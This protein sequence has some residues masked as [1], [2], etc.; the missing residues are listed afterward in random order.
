MSMRVVN[1]FE[2]VEVEPQNRGFP[3][4]WLVSSKL[5]VEGWSIAEA[6]QG[7]DLQ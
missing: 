2:V 3:S 1:L 4:P 7:I 5:E 6:G